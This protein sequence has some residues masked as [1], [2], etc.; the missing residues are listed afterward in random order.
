M[1]DIIAELFGRGGRGRQGRAQRQG[2]RGSDV[3]FEMEVSLEEVAKGGKRRVT[4]AQRPRNRG[5]DPGR[6]RAGKQIR[7][8]GLGEPGQFGGEPGDALV[9]VRYQRH[10]VFEV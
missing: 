8:R 10:P 2:V 3:T 7:L 6:H 5:D 1:E 9:T 4:L